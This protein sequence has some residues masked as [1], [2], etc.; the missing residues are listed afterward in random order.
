MIM[1]IYTKFTIP[2]YILR[3]SPLFLCDIFVFI[4]KYVCTSLPV[5]ALYTLLYTCCLLGRKVD[6]RL[7]VWYV[8]SAHKHNTTYHFTFI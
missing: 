4:F 5:D 6:T 2:F 3:I 1:I 8:C 7:P